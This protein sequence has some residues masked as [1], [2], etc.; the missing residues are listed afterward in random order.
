MSILQQPFRPPLHVECT[1]Q[2]CWQEK[3]AA[4]WRQRSKTSQGQ[5][6]ETGPTLGGAGRRGH[7]GYFVAMTEP[8]ATELSLGPCSV[9]MGVRH[10][11]RLPQA[12]W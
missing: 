7:K 3:L 9:D 2:G 5:A 10:W 6:G 4:K 1:G 12:L 8:S 11:T